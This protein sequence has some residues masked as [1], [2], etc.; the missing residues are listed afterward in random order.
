[1]GELLKAQQ[2]C[3][4]SFTVRIDLTGKDAPPEPVLDEVNR[5]LKGVS[6]ELRLR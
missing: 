6:D 4:L 2:D 5:V 3:E 1:M